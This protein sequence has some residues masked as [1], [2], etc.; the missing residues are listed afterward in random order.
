MTHLPA[1][2]KLR[3]IRNEEG[4]R[5]MLTV[6][7]IRKVRLSFHRDGKSIRHTAKDLQLSRNTI[8]KVI[9][10]DQTSFMLQSDVFSHR[11]SQRDTGDGV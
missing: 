1:A 10:S 4:G 5:E 8:R 9:R 3:K 7:T 2:S 11:L 6:E